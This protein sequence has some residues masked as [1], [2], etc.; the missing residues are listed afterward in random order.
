MTSRRAARGAEAMRARGSR[1]AA[2]PGGPATGWVTLAM[3]LALA[4]QHGAALG[5]PFL[6]DDYS[7]L[8][9]VRNASF[10]SLWQRNGLLY[11]WYRP[12]SRELHYWVLEHLFGTHERAYHLV[13]F[14]LWLGIMTLYFTL[15][16]RLVG[17]RAAALACAGVAGLAAWAGTLLW[18]AGVQEL[19]MLLFALLVLHAFARRRAL[20]AAAALAL[21]LLSKETAA[22]LPGIALVWALAVDGD[23]PGVALKRI[24]PLAVVTAAWL[25]VH[26]W[27]HA[28]VSNAMPG[29]TEAL[30]RPGVA[31]IL[32][33]LAL[34]FVNLEQRPAPASGWWPALSAGLA[35]AAVLVGFAAW[36]LA[37]R[38]GTRA[39]GPARGALALAAAWVALGALPLFA[40]SIGWHAYYGLL[41]ALGAWI[42]LAALLAPRPTL[43]LGVVAAIAVLRPL[44]ADTPSWDWSS[45]AYQQRAGYFLG[46]L[47]DDLL[48]KHPTL[49]SGSR[50]Y[51]WDVPQNIGL[52][53][54]DGAPVR[55]WY[56]DSTLRAGYVSAYAP[57]RA[58]AAVG[59]DYFFRFDSTATW[60]EVTRGAEDVEAARRANP[61]WADDHRALALALGGA[62]DW[63]GAAA[64]IEKLAAVYPQDFQYALNLGVCYEN[65]GD[66]EAARRW[67]AR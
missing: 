16:R 18:V 33:R 47:R 12:W 46:R 38:I 59:Q 39:A 67:Y 10:T 14:A 15:A 5:M 27:L 60:V 19:W 41:A 35:G 43:A 23:G 62:G 8:D 56:R 3:A 45:T 66:A 61:R 6:G 53:V 48:H 51:F 20:A 22:V 4:L 24:A 11:Y 17:G 30:G 29:N 54:G 13:S 42:L 65:L 21:A 63:A 64:E 37:P 32:G 55:V 50:L 40:R 7:I 34:S 2:P 36:A 31:G 26:P 25:I 1:A 58:V 9:K 44:R 49:P 52:I 57:R 28:V